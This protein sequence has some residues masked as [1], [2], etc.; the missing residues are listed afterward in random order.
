ML[1]AAKILKMHVVCTE[2]YPKGLGKTV[3][4]LAIGDAGVTAIDKTVFS[5][6]LSPVLEDLKTKPDVGSILLCGL[7]AHV[8]IQ[9][10]AI[11]LKSQGYEVFIIAD[12]CSSRGHAER[13]YA[14]NLL[15]QTGCWLTTTESAILALT[16]G[17]CH[18]QFKELQALIKKEGPDTGLLS[19]I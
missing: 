14:F 2:Q 4:E 3:P 6:C 10:T 9:Q 8:C 12:A 16:G 17:S 19:K 11:D 15:Q 5:M 13:K 1:Q 7:E 18:P